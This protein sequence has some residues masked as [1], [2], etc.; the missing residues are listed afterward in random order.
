MSEKSD[1][2][3]RVRESQD[4]YV[5]TIDG[6]TRRIAYDHRQP[7]GMNRNPEAFEVVGAVFEAAR[8]MRERDAELG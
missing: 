1:Q 3:A 8:K 5:V 6:K 7:G 2:P 4:Y